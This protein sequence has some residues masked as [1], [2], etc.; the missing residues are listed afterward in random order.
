MTA[1]RTIP[2]ILFVSFLVIAIPAALF[3]RKLPKA[4]LTPSEKELIDF[5]NKSVDMSLPRPQPTFSGRACPVKA[6]LGKSGDVTTKSGKPVS[7]PNATPMNAKSGLPRSL[8][9]RPAVS[10]IYYA[11]STR[12]AII[13]GHI[14]HEGSALDGS[15]IVKIEA[16]RVLMR[17]NGKDLWLT[18]E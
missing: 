14:V 3:F 18:T 12:M 2:T 17:K 6:T 9:S 13:D 16:T 10:M 1:D 4:D 11:G 7:A 15:R 8:A 5:S